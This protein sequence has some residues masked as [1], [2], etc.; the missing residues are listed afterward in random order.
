MN[1]VFFIRVGHSKGGGKFVSVDQKDIL[2]VQASR[3]YCEVHLIDQTKITLSIP[4]NRFLELSAG[5]QL[6]R[7]SRSVAVNLIAI[8]EIHTYKIVLLNDVDLR[9]TTN[10]LFDFYNSVN[11]IG[12]DAPKR[13]RKEYTLINPKVR[14]RKL[15]KPQLNKNSVLWSDDEIQVVH[16]LYLSIDRPTQEAIFRKIYMEMQK[17]DEFPKRSAESYFRKLRQKGLLKQIHMKKS[18]HPWLIKNQKFQS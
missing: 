6:R 8:K 14:I 4:L 15:V 17:Q 13:I 5:L 16:K 11:L 7:I 3:S 9:L 1:D 12:G 10:Y 2:Y 18:L